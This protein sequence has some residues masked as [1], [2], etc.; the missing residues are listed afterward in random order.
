MSCFRLSGDPVNVGL[1]PPGCH[2]HCFAVR[3]AEALHRESPKA[4]LPIVL[5]DPDAPPCPAFRILLVFPK[6]DAVALV[7]P[8]TLRVALKLRCS[9]K[10]CK[11]LVSKNLIVIPH[12]VYLRFLFLFSLPV[13]H[14][15]ALSA[16][17]S[18]SIRSIN[19]TNIC[20]RYCVYLPRAKEPSG[21]VVLRKPRLYVIGTAAPPALPS[22][23]S[24]LR[25][26]H[27]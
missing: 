22:P 4:V 23:F 14:I 11:S 15:F 8:D 10:P 17:N 24:T 6:G 3:G 19:Y 16:G 21:S 18:K 7:F 12:G 20:G 27:R 25:I 9:H 5:P 26:P 1:C 2:G 13:V